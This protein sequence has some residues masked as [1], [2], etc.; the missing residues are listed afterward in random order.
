MSVAR[1]KEIHPLL[2]A[3]YQTKIRPS[4]TRISIPV[5]GGRAAFAKATGTK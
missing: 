1:H 2:R 3:G 4:G 5:V